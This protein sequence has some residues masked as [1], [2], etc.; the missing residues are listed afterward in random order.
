MDWHMGAARPGQSI[1]QLRDRGYRA[2]DFT[3]HCRP[4]R[5]GTRAADVGSWRWLSETIIGCAG[6]GFRGDPWRHRRNKVK[7]LAVLA[8]E[9]PDAVRGAIQAWRAVDRPLALPNGLDESGYLH[10]DRTPLLD[11]VELL[12]IHLPLDPAS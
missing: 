5:L 10:G 4:Y 11:A 7:K 8:R 1:L 9:G 12:D 2:H 6:N 3:L